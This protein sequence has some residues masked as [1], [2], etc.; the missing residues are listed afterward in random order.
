MMRTILAGVLAI[1]APVTVAGA[2]V[3]AMQKADCASIFVTSTYDAP[4]GC[5]LI[6]GSV[7][8]LVDVDQWQCI[9]SG[10]R[11]VRYD[12]PSIA[13]CPGVDF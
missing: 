2:P 9:G 4:L 5:D 6:S 10:G 7:L 12:V 3:H 8:T 1:V 13:I 11:Y